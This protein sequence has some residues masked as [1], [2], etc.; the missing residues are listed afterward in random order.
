MSNVT[1]FPPPSTPLYGVDFIGPFEP[2][3]KVTSRGYL[4]PQLKATVHQNGTVTLILDDRMVIDGP[5]DEVRKWVSFIADAMAV[6][7]GYSCHGENSRQ[8]NPYKVGLSKID[9]IGQ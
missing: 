3:W 2:E 6:A 5:A 9:H 8:P 1:D 4:V 7:A